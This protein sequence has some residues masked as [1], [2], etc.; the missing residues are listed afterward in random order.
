MTCSS[1]DRMYR[2][3]WGPWR[4][5]LERW[6]SSLQSHAQQLVHLPQTLYNIRKCGIG[7]RRCP[8]L[9]WYVQPKERAL[10]V[11]GVKLNLPQ[12]LRRGMVSCKVSPRT[13]SFFSNKQ[14][15]LHQGNCP[16]VSPDTIS[17]QLNEGGE[18]TVEAK[19]VII[20]TYHP[21]VAPLK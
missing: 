17:V 16:V 3:A 13:S 19:N 15:R 10:P 12:M 4:D 2:E 11:E 8:Y 5:I 7:G 14:G 6:L 1:P 21:Q 20:A 18:S 9:Y